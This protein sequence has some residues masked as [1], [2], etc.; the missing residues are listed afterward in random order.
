DLPLATLA[1]VQLIGSSV[2]LMKLG[3]ELNYFLGLRLVAAL[4]AGAVWGG[5]QRFASGAMAGDAE[6][7]R[8]RAPRGAAL[9]VGLVAIGYGLMPGLFH[10]LAQLDYARQV[11]L[12]LLGPGRP[13]LAAL[14]QIYDRAAD[15]DAAI[16][17]DS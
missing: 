10:D 14:R 17:S 2:A 15:P 11:R 3:S 8:A 16:L 12:Y 7:P 4:G 13:T 5:V 9:A 1:A 6:R